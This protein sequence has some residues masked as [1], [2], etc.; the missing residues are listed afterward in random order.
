MESLHDKPLN[1]HP[2][3]KQKKVY[4]LWCAFCKQRLS[5]R[6]MKA[7]LLSDT[8]ANLYSTDLCPKP[9][10]DL[11]G[12]HYTTDMCSCKIKDMACTSCGNSVGYHVVLPCAKCM[13]SCNNGHFWIFHLHASTVSKRLNSSGCDVL[14]WA[15]LEIS[16]ENKS[17]DDEPC[18]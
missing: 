8:S 7:L 15:D 6:T 12:K 16:V 4:I 3:F 14:K 9:A 17:F 10:V 5:D 13:D 1:L 18:R 2:Y 11:V